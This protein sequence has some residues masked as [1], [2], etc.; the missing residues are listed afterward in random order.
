MISWHE[1]PMPCQT[2]HVGKRRA[3]KRKRLQRDGHSVCFVVRF[4]PRQLTLNKC[5]D[6]AGSCGY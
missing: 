6:L 5:R 4:E 2:K 3:A 1:Y